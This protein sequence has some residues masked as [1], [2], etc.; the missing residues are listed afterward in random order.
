[1]IKAS[2]LSVSLGAGQAVRDVSLLVRPG[3][4]I[5]VVGES[6][7][8]KTMLG[9][10]MIGMTPAA[11]KVSGSLR[12]DNAEMVGADEKSW[13]VQRARRVAM[14]FQEPMAALN[15]IKRVGDTVME[16]LIIHMGLSRAQ[17]R[18]CA[19]S[20]F[21]E[22][23]IPDP[24]ARFRQFPHEISGGQRQRVLI[25]LALTCDPG[26]LI[27][28]EPTTALDANVALRI[29]ELLARLARDRTMALLFISHDLAAVARSTEDMLVMYGGDIVERGKT[30]AV[31]SDPR[32]PYTQGLL[33]ARPRPE[34][35]RETDGR[36]KRLPTIPGAV[37]P[38]ADLPAG[39]R[40]AGRCPV[41]MSQ[42]ATVRPAEREGTICHQLEAAT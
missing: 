39:C 13:Q 30:A 37:P 41:E 35:V 33:S 34:N 14:V 8:G 2:K 15:P 9:L 26:L 40:F 27:A 32:H 7:C 6:G 23:G 3:D 21:E 19:L 29:T 31:L 22:V 36:R 17:A 4:R 28:D 38:L 18:E 42:C 12:L 16:P 25:A 24:E 5:G 11:A 10:A 20:L 1:M